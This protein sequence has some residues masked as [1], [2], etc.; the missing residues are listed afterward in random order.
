MSEKKDNC[1]KERTRK[2]INKM[3]V[4]EADVW[5]PYCTLFAYQPHRPESKPATP[6]NA[7]EK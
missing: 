3:I 4:K 2:S 7:V 5:P 1:F 6:R